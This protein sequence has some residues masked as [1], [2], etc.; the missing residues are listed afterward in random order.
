MKLQAKV[1]REPV[2]TMQK[3]VATTPLPPLAPVAS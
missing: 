3:S 2:V 1:A